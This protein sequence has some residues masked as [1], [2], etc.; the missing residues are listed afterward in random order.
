MP[1][2]PLAPRLAAACAA[3]FIAVGLIVA[4]SV[5]NLTF[6]EDLLL[7][8]VVRKAGHFA[9]FLILGWL[10][11][12]LRPMGVSLRVASLVAVLAAAG[13]AI[14]DELRQVGVA[15]RIASPIDA[16][17]DVAGAATGVILYRRIR[18]SADRADE[19]GRAP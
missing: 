19:R 14:G 4:S 16:V 8:T 15:G 9:V 10:V 6:S 13:L 12:T 11:C 7:D 17:I 2:P 1:P 18:P 3:T 5:P